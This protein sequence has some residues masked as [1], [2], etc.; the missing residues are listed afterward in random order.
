MT[1]E[2]SR[3]ENLI[4]VHL[5]CFTNWMKDVE[6]KRCEL[7]FYRDDQGHEV[8][9]VILLNRKPWIAIEA[10]LSERPTSSSLSFLMLRQKIPFGFQISLRGSEDFIRRQRFGEIRHISAARFLASLV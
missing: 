8:D 2:P 1:D 6:G 3:I 7:R 4:A 5:I 10:K 9:F